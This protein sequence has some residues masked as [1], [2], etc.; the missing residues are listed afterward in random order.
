VE[1][2]MVITDTQVPGTG[3]QSGPTQLN[4]L[5][6]AVTYLAEDILGFEFVDPSGHAL[7]PFTA[8]SHIDVRLSGGMIRQ[9][10]LCNAP[11][12]RHRYVVAVLRESNGRGGSI[13]MHDAL[14]PGSMLS[15]SAPRNHFELSDQARRYVFV[16][17][18]IGITPIMAMIA[19][20]ST[21][22][23]EFHLFYCA[24]TPR[25]A[26][27]VNVL[28]QY[29]EQ[30]EATLH[31]D[32]GDPA[33][34]LDLGAA[35]RE[36]VPGTHLYYCGPGG[37]LRAVES[38]A[39]HWPAGTRHSECFSG[40]ERNTIPSDAI[41]ETEFQVRLARTRQCFTVRPGESIVQVLRA[42]GVS[43]DVSCEE[44]YCGTC[45]TRYLAGEPQHRDSVLDED[46]RK[47]FMMVCCSRANSEELLLDL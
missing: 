21:A 14:K 19:Q 35:L 43:I 38:A 24:R 31:F 2:D 10:S 47:T 5:L 16:A 39:A 25:R 11:S 22:N 44:G 13:A 40:S 18:G 9:Y 37:L 28:R 34:M 30:G 26:A 27:F 23:R 46:D 45:M 15:I 17:G 6:R 36:Y 3:L 41:P 29:V 4:V 20:A 8:G 33:R 7:P 42:N 12:E 32:E 1:D